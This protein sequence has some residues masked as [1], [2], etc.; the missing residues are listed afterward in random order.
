MRWIGHVS[1][2]DAIRNTSKTV[3]ETEGRDLLKVPGASGRRLFTVLDIT[4]V[5]CGLGSFHLG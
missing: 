4:L 2:W 3:V 5:G 1:W